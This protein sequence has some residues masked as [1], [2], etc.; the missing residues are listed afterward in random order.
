[1]TRLPL[2]AMPLEVF[3]KEYWQ[4][5]PLFIPKAL[6]DVVSPLSAEELAGLACEDVVESRLVIRE[7]GDDRWELS[8]GPFDEARFRTLPETNWT[9]LVQAVD[10][11]VP[12]AAA[13]L[14]PFSFIPNWRIDDL[15]M[16][17]SSQHGG[18]G[19]HYDNYDVFLVQVKGTRRWEVGEAC[20][21]STPRRPDTPVTILTDWHPQ[22][23][24][25]LEPGDLL[26]VPPR[27]GH[28]GIALDSECLTCSVGFRAPSHR[29]ILRE[30]SGTMS[31]QISEEFR[32]TDPNIK[33]QSNPGEIRPE[34]LEQVHRILRHY[35]DDS[36]S[37]AKWFGQYMTSPKYPTME[38]VSEAIDTHDVEKHL[39]EGRHLSKN[40]GSRFAYIEQGGNR[41]LFVDGRVY[42]CH[43]EQTELVKRLCEDRTLD[44]SLWVN[45]KSNK[46]L[47]VNLVLNGSLYWS[48]VSDDAVSR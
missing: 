32:Y 8:H 13:F 22:E 35:V 19:P 16:S 48:D 18:V 34:A 28:N 39:A 21:E 5:K 47:I 25:T 24:Y 2:G 36:Q 44:P 43:C 4:K 30:F 17:Y 15:M 45:V 1:M 33:P 46:D 12:E 38:L 27:F 20:D 42:G 37:L 9:L 31:E 14:E 11:W 26:Y 23:S 10:H 6:P 41:W 7:D 40:E 3:L 29:E